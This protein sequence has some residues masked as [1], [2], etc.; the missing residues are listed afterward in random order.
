MINIVFLLLIF[1]MIAGQIRSQD[2]ELRLPDSQSE[3]AVQHSTLEISLDSRGD[4][5][6]NGQRTYAELDRALATLAGAPDTPVTLR[7]D[8]R[9][10]A[11]AL[12]PVLAALR[13]HGAT[14]LQIVTA[15]TP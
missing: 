2:A 9:L 15:A 5:R 13:R 8:R 12:D 3:A 14:R 7:V 6:V 4:L 11:A 10:P 1:F